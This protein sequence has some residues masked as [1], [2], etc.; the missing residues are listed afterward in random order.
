MNKYLREVIL[1]VI[2][3]IPFIYLAS[4]WNDL[5]ERVPIHF[6]GE[7]TADGWSSKTGLLCIT[8]ATIVGIYLLMLIIPIFVPKDRI[9]TIGFKYY[10]I[11]LVI[12]LF[13]SILMMFCL[14]LSNAGKV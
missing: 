4:I 5:P 10:N 1:L 2:V 3:I 11:R 7:G 12:T 6:D 14:H 8:V 9:I 13:I